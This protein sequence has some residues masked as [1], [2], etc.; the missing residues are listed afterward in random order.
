M[1]HPAPASA[2]EIAGLGSPWR[3]RSSG[4][5]STSEALG[6]FGAVRARGLATIQRPP[7]LVPR[8]VSAAL[9]GERRGL[10]W[11]D[12]DEIHIDIALAPPAQLADMLEL[13]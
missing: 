11:I 13:G 9:A 12:H 6:A 8:C 1:P 10:R 4:H 2:S 5:A 7:L 3:P